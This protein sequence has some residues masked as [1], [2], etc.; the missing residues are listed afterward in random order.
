[1]INPS[2]LENTYVVINKG[3]DLDASITDHRKKRTDIAIERYRSFANAHPSEVRYFQPILD[4]LDHKPSQLELVS[5][6]VMAE[7][8]NDFYT[9]TYMNEIILEKLGQKD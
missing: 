2:W 1:M 8:K 3:V 6:V 5:D 7:G 4:V 9:L